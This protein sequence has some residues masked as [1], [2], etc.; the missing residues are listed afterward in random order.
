MSAPAPRADGP[1][2]ALAVEPRAQRV[3]VVSRPA[4]RVR[5]GHD[6]LLRP[7]EVGLCGTDRQLLS[8]EHGAPPPDDDWLVLGHEALCEVVDAGDAVEAFAPGD[9]VVPLVRRPCDDPACTPCREGRQDFCRTGGYRERG[10]DGAQGFLIERTLDDDR[11]LVPLPEALRPVGVLTEPLTIAEKALD[12]I[13]AVQR[14]L[15]DSCLRD[16]RGTC[17]ALVLGAGPVALLG[18]L[19]LRHRGFETVVYSRGDAD[20]PESRWAVEVGARYVCSRETPPERLAEAV[21]E[22][23]VVYEATGAAGFAFDV[24]THALGANGVFVFTGIPGGDADGDLEEGPLMS[25]L[26]LRNQIALG[27]V[28]ASRADYERAV[29]DL[30][31]FETRW[32]G[33][34]AQLLSTRH[35]LDDWKAAFEGAADPVKSVIAP[36]AGRSRSRRSA[37]R[38]GGAQPPP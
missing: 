16:A 36:G 30:G 31:A 15:P 5:A 38:P 37:G 8:F 10:I 14:R 32:P 28:N 11:Y 33:K 4:P 35:P 3:E 18:A 19:A 34:L 9:L 20:R 23:H 22:A 21:G 27:T 25:D 6:V 7:L 2:R 13:D 17:L 24:L 29:A 12:Q 26:V 1:V